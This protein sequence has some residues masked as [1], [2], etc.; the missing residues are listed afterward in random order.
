[1]LRMFEV[2]SMRGYPTI[3]GPFRDCSRLT[4]NFYCRLGCWNWFTPELGGDGDAGQGLSLLYCI[5]VRSTFVQEVENFPCGADAE[6][7]IMESPIF[8]TIAF[9]GVCIP[10]GYMY[11]HYRDIETVEE[12][13]LMLYLLRAEIQRNCPGTDRL[14]DIVIGPSPRVFVCMYGIWV[15]GMTIRYYDMWVYASTSTP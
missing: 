13:C 12:D 4:V 11:I 6:D 15:W 1:M 2:W 10:S 8:G 14:I 5:F 3:W 9:T 7:F